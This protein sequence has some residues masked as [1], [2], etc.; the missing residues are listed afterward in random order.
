MWILANTQEEM[1]QN[2]QAL[3]VAQA[4][5]VTGPGVH[6]DQLA[7]QMCFALRRVEVA[8]RLVYMAEARGRPRPGQAHPD[9]EVE[10][11]DGVQGGA[12]ANSD[13][14]FS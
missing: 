10:D 2:A 6:D 3:G 5:A 12:K 8:C 14:E 11:P 1:K 7:A 4:H 13:A 9:A